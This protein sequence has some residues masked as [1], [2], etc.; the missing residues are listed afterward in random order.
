MSTMPE[1][2]KVMESSEAVAQAVRV[3]RPEVISAYP[4]SPQTHIVEGLARMAA[5]GKI[6]SEYVRVESEFSAASVLAGSSAAGARS[7]TASSSQGLLLMTEVLYASVG[8]RL[9]FVITGVNRSISAPISIQIDQRDTSESQ[10]FRYD[11]ALC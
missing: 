9:P 10:G 4:I 5:D 7:Y 8:Q 6:E 3:C 2:A 1:N 11:P